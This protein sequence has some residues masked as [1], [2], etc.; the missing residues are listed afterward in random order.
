[1]RVLA[2]ALALSLVPALATAAVHQVDQVNTTFQPDDITIQV[3][4]TVNWVWS[5]GSHT[6]TSG[7]GASDPTVGQLFD[8]PLN[9]TST[10][11]SHVFGAEGT[12]DYFCRPH[13]G[14]GMTGVV[15]VVAAPEPVPSLAQWAT[16]ALVLLLGGTLLR[17]HRARA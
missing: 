15:R 13:E 10:S 17:R 4:D 9:S 3:G 6:V 14:L 11:F 8:A 5:A 1:M 7:S 2:I 16:L 12:F